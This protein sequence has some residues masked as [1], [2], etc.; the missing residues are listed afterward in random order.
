MATTLAPDGVM[1][2]RTLA[3]GRRIDL[4]PTLF[5]C[6]LGIAAPGDHTGYDAVY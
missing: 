6:R 5:G 3:D 2:S 4:V 1:V